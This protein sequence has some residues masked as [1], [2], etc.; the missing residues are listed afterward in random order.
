MAKPASGMYKTKARN[1]TDAQLKRAKG[2]GA[3]GKRTVSVSDTKRE[4]TG[5][6]K[7]YTL[8]A[9]GKRLTGTV[10]MANGDRA[11][12]KGGKRVTNVPKTSSSKG[13]GGG[14]GGNKTVLTRGQKA[15]GARYTGMA[16]DPKKI[17]PKTDT[18]VKKTPP[19]T[20]GGSSVPKR[21]KVQTKKTGINTPAKE[22]LRQIFTGQL[23]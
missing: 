20:F 22:L 17:A 12:Y 19:K 15:A 14:G 3:A 11:V 18:T 21:S 6:N 2:A 8:S 7:G 9:S 1:L 5:A 4:T 23:R 16:K 10:V 13:G